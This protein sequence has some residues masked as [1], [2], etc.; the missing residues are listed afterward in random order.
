MVEEWSDSLHLQV[1][2]HLGSPQEV[3]GYLPYGSL[4][5]ACR[6]VTQL[7]CLWRELDFTDSPLQQPWRLLRGHP[8]VT[9][10]IFHGLPIEDDVLQDLLVHLTQL[11]SL[12][13]SRCCEL[14]P[15]VLSSCPSQLQSLSLEKMDDL[16]DFDVQELCRRCPNLSCLDLRHCERLEDV[17]CFIVSSARWQSLQPDA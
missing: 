3:W 10:L 15:Q 11:Q 12:D 8:E 2:K 13:L 9:H 17:S 7:P 16:R 14:T 5:Q 6:S 1:L 4:C